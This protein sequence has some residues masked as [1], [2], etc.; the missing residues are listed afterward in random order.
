MIEVRLEEDS[1]SYRV[2]DLQRFPLFLD[3]IEGCVH[4]EDVNVIMRV[5][6]AVDRPGLAMNKLRIHH[7]GTKPLNVKLIRWRAVE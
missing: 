5:G 1:V 6:Y 3:L 4:R 7:V 2:A